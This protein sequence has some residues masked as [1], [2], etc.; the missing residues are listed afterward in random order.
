M[1]I[2]MRRISTGHE[3]HFFQLELLR[4][5]KRK[6]Q[7]P[8]MHRIKRTTENAERTRCRTSH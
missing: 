2:T 8:D 5:F 4:D 7:V 6:P 1:R 3:T